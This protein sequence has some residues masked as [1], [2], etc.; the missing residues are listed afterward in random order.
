[1]RFLGL[2]ISRTKAGT[3]SPVDNRGNGGWFPWI[4]R[5][6]YTGAWQRNDE[7]CVD[8][9][10]ENPTVFSCITLIASDIGKLRFKVIEDQDTDGIWEET[11][12]TGYSNVLRVP[13][14]YQNHIQFKEQWVNSKLTRGNTY[15]LKSRDARGAVNA[16]YILDP[17]RVTPL[18]S[19]D[20]SVFY[21]LGLDNLA[22]LQVDNVAVPASEIIHDRMN[23][24]FHPLVGISPLFAAGL[25]ALMGTRIQRN[26][27]TFFANGAK[28]GGI[29]T[30]PGAIKDATAQR[31][32]DYWDQNF[33][34]KNAGRIA[35]LGDDLKYQSLSMTSVESQMID[36]LKWAS[37]TICGVFHVPAY[38]VG[39]GAP[40]S[41]NNIEAL[42]QGYYSQ[43]LQTLIEAMELTLDEGL[44]MPADIGVELD[45]DGL[46]RMDTN[47][48][49]K[50]V[51][52][53]ISQ[54]LLTPNEGRRRLGL[55]PLPGGDALFIQQQNFSVEAIAKR[56][57]LANPFVIDAPT[58]TPTPAAE[59]TPAAA[60]TS[61]KWY[62]DFTKALRLELT[63]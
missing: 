7:I 2:D 15:V 23:C 40:P 56:D 60:D 58:T 8:T 38:K 48:L 9:A 53:A 5:E 21:Q 30:A 63:A 6:P 3:L 20:G 10:V 1:M 45:L 24:L 43:C 34:G 61:A 13:N 37:E 39:V 51:G 59:P 46:L 31:L 54:T 25:A 62:D 55:K 29:L 14:A 47:T 17:T 36:Q 41:Y 4:V 52:D 49:Y 26:S 33:A 12:S 32:K 42:E 57:A 22:G 44:A 35:V 28:P 18:V 50:T 16:L 11:T 19:P 27:S